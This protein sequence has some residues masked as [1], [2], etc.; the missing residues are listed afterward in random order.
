MNS[1]DVPEIGPMEMVASPHHPSKSIHFPIVA[2]YKSRVVIDGQSFAMEALHSDSEFL[3]IGMF[4]MGHSLI[5][6]L[7]RSHLS[8]VRLLRTARLARALRFA[9]LSA[10]SLAPELVYFCPIFMVF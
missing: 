1:Y 5:P 4:I 8:L 2:E 6:S 10:C 9:H 7:V 3:E